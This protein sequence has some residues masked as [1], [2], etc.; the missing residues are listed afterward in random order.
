MQYL[1]SHGFLL[2]EAGISLIIVLIFSSLVFTWHTNLIRNYQANLQ[3][4]QALYAAHSTL[5][6]IRASLPISKDLSW[7][8]RIEKRPIPQLPS[9]AILEVS[10]APKKAPTKP[11][12]ILRTICR[13]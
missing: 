6:K 3:S 7:H 1:K 5:E 11:L 2:L 13:T 9:I 8:T 4:I 12:I 10:V